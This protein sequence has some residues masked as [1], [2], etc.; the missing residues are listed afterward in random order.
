MRCILFRRRILKLV[1]RG[2]DMRWIVTWFVSL[3][4]G[5]VALFSLA[6]IEHQLNLQQ[7]KFPVVEERVLLP[8]GIELLVKKHEIPPEM[9]T[10]I[11][12]FKQIQLVTNPLAFAA[13]GFGALGLGWYYIFHRKSC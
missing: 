3:L 12:L 2:Q 6:T 5:L 10:R 4:I 13:T 9:A 7:E 11:E 8:S 1:E